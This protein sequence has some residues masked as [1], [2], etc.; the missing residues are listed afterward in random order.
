MADPLLNATGYLN[1]LQAYWWPF[2]RILAVLAMAPLL[3]HK[4][5]SIRVRMLLA[6]A[7]TIAL[8]GALP[9]MPLIEPLSAKGLL[10]ALEQVAFGVLMGLTLQL[11]FTL[12]MVVGEVVSTQMGLSMAR[13]NDPMNGVSSSSILYQVYFIALA[14][15]FLAIDGHLVVV[16]VLYSSF[17]LWPVGSGL[18]Y[19]GAESF[20]HALAWVI[21]GAV[22]VT[23]PIVF[24]LT[25]VQFCFGL[26]N[27]ISPS[28]NLFSLGFPVSVLMGLLCLYLTLPDLPQHYLHLTRELL[29]GL[30]VILE[31]GSRG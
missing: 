31:E 15:M 3:N 22:L 25:L 30:G 17:V 20:V 24:C 26:L 14:L 4:A 23:L 16:S 28:M 29:N 8:A 27:R 18:H 2:C 12:F 13:F 9:D 1:S 6:L 11:V 5:V 19:L 10:T 7:I 21:A